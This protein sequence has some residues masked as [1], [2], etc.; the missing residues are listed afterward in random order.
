MDA[1]DRRDGLVIQVDGLSKHYGELK[2]VDGVSFG[3]ERGEVFGI[4]G[5]NGAGKTT[6]LECIE[7]LTQPTSGKT[8]V[9]GFDTQREPQQV[10]QRIGVQLQA[11]A[12]FDYLT[13]KEILDLFGKFYDRRVN[14]M[15]LLEQVNLA[16][17]ASATVAKLSGGQQQRFS[18]AAALVNDP[19]VV[20]LDEPSTG[21]DPQARRNLWEFIRSTNDAGR[22]VVLTT[23]YMEEAEYLC[24]RIAIMDDGKL[25]ALDT[26]ASLIGEL[27]SPY[28]I[29]I[30]LS[31]AADRGDE[32]TLLPGI[33]S[34]RLDD[35]G[36]YRLSCVDASA[37]VAALTDWAR[38]SGVSITHLEIAP[39]NLEDV[40]LAITGRELRE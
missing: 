29:R 27:P 22:T 6:T 2:A 1:Q 5:P 25:I 9:L 19:D 32:L 38:M 35:G 15:E 26:P 14:P 8:T 7:G 23:H 3:V 34:A 11:S 10:K 17:R 21:L 12:Y 30:T 31:D 28:E 4:L 40:F 20:F 13:L 39:S 24:D 33:E 16:D 18:I 37:S 36:I